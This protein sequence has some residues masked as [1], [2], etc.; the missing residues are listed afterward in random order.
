MSVRTPILV[1]SYVF[2]VFVG[3]LG[4]FAV[5]I[6]DAVARGDSDTGF[7]LVALP[8]I[9]PVGTLLNFI[10]GLPAFALLRAA[11]P[12]KGLG[13]LAFIMVI[14][15]PIV[16]FSCLIGTCWI[17]G[18]SQ[19]SPYVYSPKPALIVRLSAAIAERGRL[20]LVIAFVGGLACWAFDRRSLLSSKDFH[21]RMKARYVSVGLSAAFIVPIVLMLT[22]N[23]FVVRYRAERIAGDRPYCILVPKLGGSEYEPATRNGQLSFM[24]MR[25]IYTLTT[26]SRGG[27]YETHHALLVVD[28]PPE[29]DKLRDYMYWS[30]RA[31]NFLPNAMSQ[32]TRFDSCIPKANFAA[33][34]N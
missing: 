18:F 25:A 19:Y 31:E 33:T 14:L 21:V 12:A 9:L 5:V 1:G 24:N 32:S 17:D 7:V 6:A 11:T 22:C 10:W 27:F 4:S 15:A 29:R 16:C 34:L 26:G 13:R 28:N 20:I 30:Y 3:T 8:V 23:Q 2:G